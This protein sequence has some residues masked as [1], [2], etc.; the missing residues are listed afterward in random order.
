MTQIEDDDNSKCLT[1]RQVNFRHPR[2]SKLLLSITVIIENIASTQK[3]ISYMLYI[4]KG[5][6]R[7][8]QMIPE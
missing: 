7:D 2:F 8:G 3:V 4:S 1:I 6:P 5:K